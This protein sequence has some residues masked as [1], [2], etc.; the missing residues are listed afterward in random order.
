ML[1]ENAH[2]K[3]PSSAI[4]ITSRKLRVVS[5]N[6]NELQRISLARAAMYT[7]CNSQFAGYKSVTLLSTAQRIA[8]QNLPE[9]IDTL[10]CKLLKWTKLLKGK[11]YINK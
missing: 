5:R 2:K 8:G 9:K 1:G 7:L 6:F 3:I 10:Y 4:M 11:N